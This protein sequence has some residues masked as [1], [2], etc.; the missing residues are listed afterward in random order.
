MTSLAG[1]MLAAAAMPHKLTTSPIVTGTSVLGLRYRDGVML[2]SDTLGSYGSL[3]RFTEL[4]RI[5]CVGDYT[6]VA[7]S[8]EYSDFQSIMDLLHEL[9]LDEHCIDDNAKLSAQEIHSYLGRVMYNKRNKADPYYNKLLIAGHKDGTAYL[10][11]LD[12]YGTE[13]SDNYTA[14]GFGAHMALPIIRDR[15]RSD[16]TEGEARAILEDCMRILWYRDTRALNKIQLAKITAEGSVISDP[17][18]LDTKWDYASFVNPKA[19]SETGG[20]W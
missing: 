8:G 14:T 15:W 9:M 18:Q 4:R 6:L 2:A 12:M 10:G 3:A 7:G 11:Y 19:G 20:S 13:F 16:L 1:P 5:R 17:Y